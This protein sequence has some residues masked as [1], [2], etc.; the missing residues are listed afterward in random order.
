MK[1]A[2]DDI[3][4][5]KYA[6]FDNIFFDKEDKFEMEGGEQA[7]YEVIVMEIEDL[8]YEC[9]RETEDHLNRTPLGNQR[10]FNKVCS[11][12]RRVMCGLFPP[13]F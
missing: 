4:S 8:R 9:V 1:E 10:E 2:I 7:G 5:I 12:K 6:I 13:V 11:I 3:M